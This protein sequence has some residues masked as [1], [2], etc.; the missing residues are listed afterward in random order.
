MPASSVAVQGQ[1]CQPASDAT[2]SVV[3]GPPWSDG[4]VRD[5]LFERSRR[6]S[7][8]R[9]LERFVGV[10]PVRLTV[11]EAAGRLSFSWESESTV[12]DE[13]T[14][15]RDMG[16][17]EMI[18]VLDSLPPP[19]LRYSVSGE[20]G[21]EIENI[22]DLR[23]WPAKFLRS[24]ASA[25]SESERLEQVEQVEQMYAAMPSEVIAERFADLP[26]LLHYLDGSEFRP[27]EVREVPDL[28]PNLLGGE[29]IPATTRHEVLDLIDDDGCVAIKVRTVP[30]TE[31]FTAVVLETLR[32][33]LP[34]S[35]TEEDLRAELGRL[36]IELT[37]IAQFDVG[38]GFVR[39]V[40]STQ[41]IGSGSHIRIDTTVITDM[42]AG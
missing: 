20:R 10:T 3:V 24:F 36:E 32:Q 26:G 29:P 27:G 31:A 35:L 22:E 12:F 39:R 42:T 8:T 40:T 7:R 11:A 5:L 9:D 15:F 33:R 25:S 23:A 18:A 19:S 14:F 1:L 34:G 4:V 28:V 2:T 6:D 38:S 17:V 30:D 21:V 16:A 41:R 37:T 13:S